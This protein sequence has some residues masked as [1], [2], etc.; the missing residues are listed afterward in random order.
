MINDSYVNLKIMNSSLLYLENYAN[1][2]VKKLTLF[3]TWD[4]L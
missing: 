3:R 2:D 4:I 1:Y